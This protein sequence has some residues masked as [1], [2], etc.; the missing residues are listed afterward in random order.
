M[1]NQI[2]SKMPKA[3]IATRP[4]FFAITRMILPP[5]MRP[6]RPCAVCIGGR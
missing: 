1:K 4:T 6:G 5:T 3:I 2:V